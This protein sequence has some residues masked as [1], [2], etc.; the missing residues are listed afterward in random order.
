MSL[1]NPSNRSRQ[2]P[3]RPLPEVAE[4]PGSIPG[5]RDL[6]LSWDPQTE[7][8]TD[9]K[10]YATFMKRNLRP[11]S[12]PADLLANIQLALAAVDAENAR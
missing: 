11:L 10:T 12:P 1:Q 9:H 5:G 7:E 6:D 2:T 8:L 3:C 4:Q